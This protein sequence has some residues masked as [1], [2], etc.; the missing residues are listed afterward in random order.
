MWTNIW[1]SRS[2]KNMKRHPLTQGFNEIFINLF[3]LLFQTTF[4]SPPSTDPS[5]I[6]S[7]KS[8][9]ICIKTFK[10]KR[11][12]S[13]DLLLHQRLG[14]CP[15]PCSFFPSHYTNEVIHSGLI[16]AQPEPTLSHQ[17]P[18]FFPFFKPDFLF[19]VVHWVISSSWIT[20]G[21]NWNINY[22]YVSNHERK[23][24]TF[25]AQN[26]FSWWKKREI[27]LHFSFPILHS[28]VLAAPNIHFHKTNT[29]SVYVSGDSWKGFTWYFQNHFG[30]QRRKKFYYKKQ[31]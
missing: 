8:T 24:W 31:R 29:I 9:P 28:L 18:C 12:K 21:S 22:S 4:W 15:E 26:E 14:W 13:W 19:N 25:Y 2:I 11:I 6:R 17:K 30:F 23:M 3:F 10:Q 7:T 1:T 5:R 16:R 20:R 27:Y